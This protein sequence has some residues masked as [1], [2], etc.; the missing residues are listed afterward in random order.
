MDANKKYKNSV[1]SLL[2]SDPE[3][4]KELYCALEGVTLPVDVPVTINC[5][6]HID[7][8]NKD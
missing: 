5:E 7:R 3:V 1:F 6:V 4:L 2:F 8:F